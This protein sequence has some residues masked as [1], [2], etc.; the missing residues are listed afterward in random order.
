SNLDVAVSSKV[1]VTTSINFVEQDNHLGTDTG[2]SAMLGAMYGHILLQPDRRGFGLGYPPEISWELYDNSAKVS[3]FTTSGTINYNMTNWL[4]HRL[5]IGVDH[6]S[7]D[8][9]TLERFATPDL[10]VYLTPTGARGLV[11]QT[12][13]LSRNITLDYAGT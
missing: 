5:L 2:L 8:H 7:G 4:R 11:G 13:R 10:A 9:R 12:L 6:T 3:R 1:N